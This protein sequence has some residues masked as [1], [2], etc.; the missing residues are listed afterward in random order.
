MFEEELQEKWLS[1]KEEVP[2]VITMIIPNDHGSS[3][4][5]NDGYPLRESYIANNDLALGR[6]I[7][8]LS[9]PRWW[10]EMLIIV[11]EDELSRTGGIIL[12][13]TVHCL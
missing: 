7:D 9:H 4:R 10:P 12:M 6:V 13:L 8:K 11:T 3:E 1:G 5:I 2:S